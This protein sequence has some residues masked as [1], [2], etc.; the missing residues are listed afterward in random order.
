M[1]PIHQIGYNHERPPKDGILSNEESSFLSEIESQ[2]GAS[3]AE[4]WLVATLL[5][6]IDNIKAHTIHF[7]NVVNLT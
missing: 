6:V 5:V 3:V 1:F 7:F 4:G 2:Y